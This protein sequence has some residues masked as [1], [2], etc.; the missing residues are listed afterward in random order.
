MTVTELLRLRSEL[1]QSSLI[2]V[3]SNLSLHCCLIN[4]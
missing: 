3:I 1:N 2:L 4:Q